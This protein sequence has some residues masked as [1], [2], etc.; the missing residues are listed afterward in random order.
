[1]HILPHAQE[2][3][4]QPTIEKI[5]SQSGKAAQERKL[6]L[7]QLNL[8]YE[9]EWLRLFIPQRYQGLEMDLPQAL[10]ILEALA[11]ADGSLGWT[12]NLGAGANLFAA[13]IR[14]SLSEQVFT[15]QKACTA[16]S[17][18]PTG[19]ARP[20]GDGYRVRGQWKYGSGS[21]HATLFTANCML[22]HNGKASD[23]PNF[24]SFVFFPDEVNIKNTWDSYGLQATSSHDFELEEQWLSEERTFSLLKPSPYEDGPLYRFP[25]MQFGELTTCLQLTGM[26]MHFLDETRS[27]LM[28]KKSMTGESLKDN[29]KV[30]D[31][32]AQAE[33]GLE[34]ARAWLYVLVHEAW[35][36]CKAGDAPSEEILR[37]ISLAV[38]H[39][40]QSARVSAEKVYPLAGMTVLSPETDLNR[41]WRDLHTATQHVLLS[42]LD[43]AW[44]SRLC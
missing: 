40:A 2:I 16:G 31:T 3:L 19:N 15:D 38:K 22:P 33:A 32:L 26:T 39:A 7:E 6:T 41:C 9:K 36:Q 44:Q 25:F 35:Q 14:P 5:R 20:E 18:A 8:I 34:S 12:V 43:F 42:P 11:Y 27:L 13:Y 23:L 24:H 37:K 4:D 1:M 29:A 10:Q 30:Q 28:Q 21:S 17:G